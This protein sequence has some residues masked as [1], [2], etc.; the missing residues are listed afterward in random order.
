MSLP[1]ISEIFAK[2]ILHMEMAIAYKHQSYGHPRSGILVLDL[3]SL[4]ADAKQV[5]LN[6]GYDLRDSRDWFV[7]DA[8]W[9]CYKKL[10]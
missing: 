4:S 8:D 9:K 6:D 5:L 10:R 7:N 1:T 3:D 2:H